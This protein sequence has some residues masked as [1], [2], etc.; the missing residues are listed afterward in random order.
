[1]KH[2]GLKR[3]AA[4]FAAAVMLLNSLAVTADAGEIGHITILGDSISSGFALDKSDK[5]YGEWLGEFYGADV[6]NFAVTGYTTQNVLDNLEEEEVIS[7]VERSDLVCVSVGANDVMDAVF[8]DLRSISSDTDSQTEQMRAAIEAAAEQM[9]KAA[10]TA[11]ENI[12][13]ISG[14]LYEINPDAELVFQTVYIPFE[15]EVS[16]YQGLLSM[17]S[18]FSGIYL[19]PINAAVRAD[20]RIVHADIQKKFRGMCPEFTNISRFDIHPNRLGHLMI[21]EEI[22]QI[23]GKNGEFS[24]IAD[25]FDALVEDVSAIDEA[26]TLEIKSLGEGEFRP[27]PA[28][29]ETEAVTEPETERAESEIV[30]KKNYTLWLAAGGAG[31]V[32][33]ATAVILIIKKVR[34]NR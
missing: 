17:L 4:A 23:V 29:A 7:S 25:G 6:E 32:I 9:R 34:K 28:E 11:S 3:K 8:N 26:L 14:K 1:M 16:E 13:V 20:E 22:V 24:V 15:T 12:S 10:D 19:A 31:A 2:L 27:E 33:A 5:N 18:M 30:E 21:A